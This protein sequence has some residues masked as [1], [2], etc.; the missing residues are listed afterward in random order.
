MYFGVGFVPVVIEG[1]LSAN[2]DEIETDVET[3]Q[4]EIE[5]L[6]PSQIVAVVST[7]SCFAPRAMDK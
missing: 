2:G 4:K 3:L 7:T 1:K 6:G 5:R